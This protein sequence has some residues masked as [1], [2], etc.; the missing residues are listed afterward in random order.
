MIT[1]A[2][3][4]PWLGT[5][6]S[7]HAFPCA[8]VPMH[9]CMSTPM[10]VCESVRAH[11]HVCAWLQ[12]IPLSTDV[13]SWAPIRTGRALD[14]EWGTGSPGQLPLGQPSRE[15][16]VWQPLV[17]VSVVG[18]CHPAMGAGA[19]GSTAALSTPV[20]RAGHPIHPRVSCWAPYPPPCPVL[21][22]LSLAACPNPGTLHPSA[23]C[24]LLPYPSWQSC[25]G[26]HRILHQAVPL[27]FPGPTGI[28]VHLGASVGG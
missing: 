17:C 13:P 8:H 5:A 28:I 16:A 23:I 20:P 7:S 19:G 1:A 21:G 18:W 11:G 3:L 25:Q 12:A 9:V 27:P 15:A 6:A 24:L 4:T 2:A 22:T 10:A 14:M 26:W